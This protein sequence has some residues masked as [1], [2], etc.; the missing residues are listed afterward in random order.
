MEEIFIFKDGKKLGRK[1][2]PVFKLKC[3]QFD[4]VPGKVFMVQNVPFFLSER[5]NSKHFYR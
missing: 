2:R 5:N 3:S 4:Q 1:I